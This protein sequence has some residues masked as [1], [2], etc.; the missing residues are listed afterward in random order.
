[1][2][3]F[4]KNW[5][6]RYQ[7]IAQITQMFIRMQFLMNKNT[8]IFFQNFHPRFARG[9]VFFSFISNFEPCE[10]WKLKFSSQMLPSDQFYARAWCFS[11]FPSRHKFW[12]F[13]GNLM[14]QKQFHAKKKWLKLFWLQFEWIL[15]IELEPAF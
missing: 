6:I 1:M 2:W 9:T 11:K 10:H 4:S 14:H 7:K 12:P 13:F 15:S 8:Y 5:T 3:I